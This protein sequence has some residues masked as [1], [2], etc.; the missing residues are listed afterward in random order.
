MN[1]NRDLLIK[2]GI[3]VFVFVITTAFMSDLFENEHGVGLLA[4]P[5]VAILLTQT[6]THD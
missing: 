3:A 2:T 5:M 6:P 4:I 1:N